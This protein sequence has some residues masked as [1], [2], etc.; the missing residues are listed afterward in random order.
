MI[1]YFMT[2]MNNVGFRKYLAIDFEKRKFSRMCM[3]FSATEIKAKDYYN[4]LKQCESN[5][6]EEV[7][8]LG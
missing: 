2:K 4:I 8:F 3:V 1:L 5:G 6:F 7:D